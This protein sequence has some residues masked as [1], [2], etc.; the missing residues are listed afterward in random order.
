[1]G[2]K[3]FIEACTGKPVRITLLDGKTIKGTLLASD[4]YT[5]LVQQEREGKQIEVLLYKHA[6]KHV[7]R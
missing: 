4:A 1:M 3:E 7:T 6:I 5:L 2:Q